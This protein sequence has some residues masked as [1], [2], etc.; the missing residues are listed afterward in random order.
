MDVRSRFAKSTDRESRAALLDFFTAI[1]TSKSTADDDGI[2]EFYAQKAL[3]PIP[4]DWNE[5]GTRSTE[6]LVHT[7]CLALQVD[8]GNAD[9][10]S[11]NLTSRVWRNTTALESTRPTYQGLIDTTVL[12]PSNTIKF[13]SKV[14]RRV[15]TKC[16]SI[17][18]SGKRKG[19]P[20]NRPTDLCNFHPQATTVVFT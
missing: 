9:P 15:A 1:T 14:N 11:T 5:Y 8:L 18:K 12:E 20:C 4:S 6:W 2:A 10:L 17:L 3:D 7:A 16:P 13:P 19:L